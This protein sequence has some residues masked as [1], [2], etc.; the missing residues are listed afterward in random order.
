MRILVTGGC[1]QLGSE[2]ARIL[3]EG[4][5]EIGP[6]PNIYEGAEVVAAD[7]DELDI[8]DAGAVLACVTQGGFDLVVNC[9]AM[10][11]VDGCEADEEEA[12]QVNALGPENLARACEEAGAKLVQVSTDYVFPGDGPE[13]RVEGDPVA[14]ASAYGRSK[15]AGED[16]VLAACSRCFVIRSAWLY[17]YTGK[18]FVKTMMRLGADREEVAVV[19]DQ[20]GNPTSAN[21]LAH[22]ILVIAA[23][24][25]Y[26][27]WHC[28]GEGTCSWADFAQAVMEGAGLGCRVAR[29]TSAEYA[30]ANPASAKR[31]AYSSLRNKRLE[32]TMGDEMRPWREALAEYLENLPRL[33]S[34]GA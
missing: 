15:L 34:P 5:S 1:G 22:E 8:T 12:F 6:I 29:C 25:G 26:G 32:D 13:P 16:R 24:E 20:L 14:P 10:T 17:G 28:T 33:G 19:D 30:A 3:R 31:P 21:D 9:A 27:V 18:N 11:N 7:V 4:R 23:T 2:L